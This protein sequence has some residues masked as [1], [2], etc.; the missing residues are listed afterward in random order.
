MGVDQ[1][2]VGYIIGPGGQNL[3]EIKET[4]GAKVYIDQDTRDH[5]YSIIRIGDKGTPENL[6][7]KELIQKKMQE[8]KML[9]KKGLQVPTGQVVPPPDASIN[10]APPTSAADVL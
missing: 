8:C 7:A 4:S 3:R 5:G 9:Q 10:G 2:Y 6:L 1:K